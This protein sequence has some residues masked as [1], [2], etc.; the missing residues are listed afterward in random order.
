MKLWLCYFNE[1]WPSVR[2]SAETAR[3][4]Q[5]LL[6]SVI[7]DMQLDIEK[8]SALESGLCH[9]CCFT[10]LNGSLTALRPHIVAK[11]LLLKTHPLGTSTC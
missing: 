9:G 7:S 6:L 10:D 11:S 5:G 1:L 2:K 3:E 8:E 4:N